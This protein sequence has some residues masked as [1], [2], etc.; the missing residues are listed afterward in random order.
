MAKNKYHD[1]LKQVPLFASLDRREL[2]AVAKATTDVDAAAGTTLMR[3]DHTGRELIVVVDGTL[4]VTRGGD[5]VADIGR[6]GFAGELA[7]IGRT[8]RNSTVATK[9]EASLIHIDGR[10]F[11][12]LLSEIPEIAVKMLPIIA[13]RAGSTGADDHES[14]APGS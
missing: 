13:A 4:E 3:E 12:K 9:T 1:Y 10:D 7:L 2:D 6:G 11:D 14:G 5:H 8:K